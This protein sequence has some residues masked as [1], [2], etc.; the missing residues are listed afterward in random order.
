MQIRS[1]LPPSRCETPEAL[2]AE[3]REILAEGGL[4]RSLGV[5]WLLDNLDRR[6]EARA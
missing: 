4:C 2:K 5:E 6:T 3:V 1:T